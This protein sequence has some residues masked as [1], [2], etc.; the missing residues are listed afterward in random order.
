MRSSACGPCHYVLKKQCKWDESQPGC[1]SRKQMFAIN[2]SSHWCGFQCWYKMNGTSPAQAGV[3]S[4]QIKGVKGEHWNAWLALQGCGN[5]VISIELP[6]AAEGGRRKRVCALKTRKWE[7][8]GKKEQN[9]WAQKKSNCLSL[10]EEL[11][12]DWFQV[13]L[14]HHQISGREWA[15]ILANEWFAFV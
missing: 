13:C 2:C 3:G 7:L 6:K 1:A 12:K 4:K 9:R 15:L 14:L 5:P 10:L 8:L 11:D